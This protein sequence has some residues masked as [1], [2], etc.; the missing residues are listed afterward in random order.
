MDVKK[1]VKQS[2]YKIIY[3]IIVVVYLICLNN[4]NERLLERNFG[5]SFE[6]LAYDNG[7]AMKYFIYAM[8]LFIVGCVLVYLDFKK[9]IKELENYKEIK[10]TAITIIFLLT[11]LIMIIIFINNPILRAIM[12]SILVVLGAGYLFTN[13]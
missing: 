11:L 13:S 7:I 5:S 6:L 9:L 3:A 12:C 1:Y 2:W 10:L 8:I 4:L